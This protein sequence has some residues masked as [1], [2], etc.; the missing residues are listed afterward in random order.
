M[1]EKAAGTKIWC[2]FYRGVRL[3]W[4]SVLK[5]STVVSKYSGLNVVS[6]SA[7]QKYKTI[8]SER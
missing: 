5:G 1:T 4:V 6:L 3:I 2:P 8:S 7:V